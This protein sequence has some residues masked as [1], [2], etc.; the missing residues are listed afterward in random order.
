MISVI[1]VKDSISDTLTASRTIFDELRD[2][3]NELLLLDGL[4]A[5]GLW[6]GEAKDKCVQIQSQLKQYQTSIKELLLQLHSCTVLLEQDMR[7]FPT[8]SDSLRIISS[9]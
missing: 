3:E 5:Q 7:K 9:I 2:V 1:E 6:T 8:M 4:L